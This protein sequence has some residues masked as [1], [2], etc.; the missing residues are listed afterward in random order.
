MHACSR[1]FTVDVPISTLQQIAVGGPQVPIEEGI[2]KWVNQRV[3]ITQP[4]KCP[5]NPQRDATARGPTD[6]GSSSRKDEKWQPAYSKGPYNYSKGS[7]CFLLPFEDRN[8]LP[9][10]L[11]QT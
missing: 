11:K 4:E 10:M 8:V 3:G 1:E 2:Y 6:E 9:F 5:L 7:G